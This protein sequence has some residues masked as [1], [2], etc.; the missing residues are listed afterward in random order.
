VILES[1]FI[2][3]SHGTTSESSLAPELLKRDVKNI[4]SY[5]SKLNVP[6]KES[7]TLYEELISLIRK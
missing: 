6:V 7:N 2:D 1:F 4:N 3:F 5:F